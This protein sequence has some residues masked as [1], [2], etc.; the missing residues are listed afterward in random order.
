MREIY[1]N[2]ID[3]LSVGINHFVKN[4]DAS[5]RKHTI[6][7]LFHAIELLLKEYLYRVNPILIYRNID[8]KIT[9]ESLT[10][11][12]AE[13]LIRLENLKLSLPEEPIKVIKKIQKRRN[14][15]EHYRYD[16]KEEDEKVISEC[17]KFVLFFVESILEE[18]LCDDIDTEQLQSIQAIVLKYNERTN[19]AEIRL[20]KWLQ[21]Q[22]PDWDPESMELPAE[23]SGTLE[24]PQ[25]KFET[26]IFD[27]KN[28]P[29]CFWCNSTINIVECESCRETYKLDDEHQC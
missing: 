25:C 9:D 28:Y 19:I 10:V 17:F 11:S 3:S 8:K 29:Y 22:W 2:A 23:F 5:S 24:C 14:Q 21:K 13:I 1:E 6:L 7:T 12:F 15:I 4:D 27:E 18:R 20:E 16:R 26:L